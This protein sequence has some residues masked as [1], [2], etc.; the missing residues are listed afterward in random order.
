MSRVL[1]AVVIA[2]GL[3]V[4]AGTCWQCL[5]PEP[6]PLRGRALCLNNLK[7]LGLALKQY[8]QDFGGRY[9]WRV[10]T[11]NPAEAWLDLG[12][13]FPVY[14]SRWKSFLCPSSK[15]RLFNPRCTRGD[16]IHYGLEPLSSA[17][18][19]EVISYAYCIDASDREKS[20][21]WTARSPAWVLLLADKK[22]GTTIGSPGNPVNFANHGDDGRNIVYQDGHVRWKPNPW[23][24]DPSEDDKIGPPNAT[25]YRAWWSDPP[26]YGE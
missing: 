9:P 19:K 23:P 6:P 22:A 21:S 18:S 4:L 11:V 8:G 13:L 17:T 15:D 12:M 24:L 16:K 25:D 3:L 20:R 1:K 2:V 10:G 5:N 26:Y 14:T 7:Q